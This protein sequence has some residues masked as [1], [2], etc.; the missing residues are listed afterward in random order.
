MRKNLCLIIIV[1]CSFVQENH[2]PV[3]KIITPAG[4]SSY[5]WNAIINYSISVSDKEDGESKFQEIVADEV[6]LKVKWLPDSSG[7][8]AE[9]NNEPAGLTVIRTS[10]CLNCHAFNS[11][12]IGPSFYEINKH[13]PYTKANSEHLQKSIRNGSTGV[14]GTISM[15]THPELN[16][17][18]IE[19]AAE[20]VLK[21]AADP[22]VYYFRGTEGSIKLKSPAAA[23]KGI[24][25]LIASYN[26][27][28][29]KSLKGQDVVVMKVK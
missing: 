18:Q 6:F 1:L 3:V 19:S 17:Q 16:K 2:P 5:E 26:D 7:L 8:K 11:K 25:A 12:L 15:P 24:L 10:N 4:R 22:D 9:I 21:N 14:W 27:H 28:G 29:V 23:G 20:W 13:Y